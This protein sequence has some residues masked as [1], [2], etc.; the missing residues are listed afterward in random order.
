MHLSPWVN[1]AGCDKGFIERGVLAELQ[2]AGK[3]KKI[4]CI[5]AL[6]SSGSEYKAPR[7]HCRIHLPEILL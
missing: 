4:M 5:S 7:G 2:E 6:S 3:H 1:T